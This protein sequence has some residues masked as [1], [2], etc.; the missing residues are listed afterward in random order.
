VSVAMGVDIVDGGCRRPSRGKKSGRCPPSDHMRPLE[1][2][3]DQMHIHADVR[4]SVGYTWQLPRMQ[5]RHCRL[6]V[7]V[8]SS[9][10]AENAYV[11]ADSQRV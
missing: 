1:I 9:S 6:Q 4:L 11:E 8:K 10:V 5:I 7:F 3:Q 2:A